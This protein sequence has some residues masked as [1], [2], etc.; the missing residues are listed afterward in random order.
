MARP[1]DTEAQIE[2][3]WSDAIS[4]LVE[5]TSS[6]RIVDYLDPSQTRPDTP[7]ERVRQ[8]YA[9]T[10]HEEYQYPKECMVFSAPIQI[11]SETKEAD[12]VIY[13]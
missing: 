1:T 11:G 7:E 13:R 4:D 5:L 9:R 3:L 2:E 8:T 12:I 10:L 6:G